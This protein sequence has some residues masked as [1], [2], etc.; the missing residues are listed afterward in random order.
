M[1][2][3]ILEQYL[4]FCEVGLYMSDLFH[5]EINIINTHLYFIKQYENNFLIC[6]K[7]HFI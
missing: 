6:D 5:T 7:E 4:D 1:Y 3:Q 2:L